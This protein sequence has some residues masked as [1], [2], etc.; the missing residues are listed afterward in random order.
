MANRYHFEG[1]PPPKSPLQRYIYNACD[2]VSNLEPNLA[3]NLEIVDLVNQ[4]KGSAPREAAVTIVQLI[5]H[6]NPNVSLL[7]LGLLDNCVKNC[8]YPFHLQISTKEFLNELVRRFPE[9]PPIRPSRVQTRILE[10]IEEWRATLCQT[11]KYKEDLG[12]IRDMH[13]LLLYKGY[14]FP[15]VR[16]DDAAVLNE[17]ENLKSA[18]ELEEEERTAQSAKL[19]ELI[20]RGTPHDLQEANRLMKV[21][22]GYD[23]RNKTDYRAKAAEEVNKVQQKARILEEMLQSVKEGDNIEEGDVFEELANALQSAH[24]KIQKMCEE[25]SDDA[26]AVAKLL[27][28]NDSIHRT[29]ERYK[30]IKVGKVQAA[31]AIPKGT[32]GTSTGVGRNAKNEL[33]LIDFD[34]EPAPRTAGSAVQV[35]NGS[36]LE[37]SLSSGTQQTTSVEDDLLGL[38]IGGSMGGDGGIALGGPSTTSDFFASVSSPTPSSVPQYSGSSA[39]PSQPST[40]AAR[41]NYDAFASITSSLISSKPVSPRPGTTATK[42]PPQ[43]P[44]IDPFAA[45]VSNS[46]PHTPSRQQN[47][48]HTQGPTLQTPAGESQPRQPAPQTTTTSTEE[49]WAFQS[50][51]PASAP[52]PQPRTPVTIPAHN[53]GKLKIDLQCIRQQT[54]PNSSPSGPIPIYVR[55]TFSNPTPQPI[56][57]IHFQV[58]VERSYSLQLKPQTSR[59]L[60]PG[61]TSG[62][63]Q[64]VLVSGVPAGKGTSV[65]MRFKVSYS[66]AGQVV[67]EQGMVTSLGV[68]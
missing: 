2:P 49:D 52:Q 42:Q 4:K 13:R 25:E 32:L 17:S 23:T 19:Q 67:E 56:T 1:F 16:R 21:M 20:R 59:D 18:E 55:A 26:E 7:A 45:L 30:L 11:S 14:M 50:A 60:Q 38:S 46:R 3:L 33:S 64:D 48:T 66:F 58:A 37:D 65:K 62:V 41:P 43:G 28:I 8:G 10:A 51:P 36:L 68:L 35:S 5:N 29:V 63:T 6:R 12:F 40:Q 27:E 22:A 54:Q 53:T 34:S 31:N 39:S 15:E 47:G 61:Q 57:N 44:T 24:P 9:R